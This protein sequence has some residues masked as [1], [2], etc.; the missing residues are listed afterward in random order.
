MKKLVYIL[1]IT[2][3]GVLAACNGSTGQ[4][5]GAMADSGAAGSSGAADTSMAAGSGA[6]VGAS[7]GGTDTSTTGSGKG[8]A[9]PTIDT[10]RKRP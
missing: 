2:G 6:P 1:L 3:A 10:G 4:T 8:V 9:D 5:G 7:T